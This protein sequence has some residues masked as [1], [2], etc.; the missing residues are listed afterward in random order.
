MEIPAAKK[1]KYLAAISTWESQPRHTLIETQKL[2]GKLLYASLIVPAG[3]AYLTEL[4]AMLPI[5]GD[6]PHVPHTPP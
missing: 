5:F 1:Q 2:F 6:R 3:R 4:E